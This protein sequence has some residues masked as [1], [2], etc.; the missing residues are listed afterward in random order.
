MSRNSSLAGRPGPSRLGTWEA[1]TLTQPT[2]D[3]ARRPIW[4]PSCRVPVAPEGTNRPVSVRLDRCPT[5]GAEPRP[6]HVRLPAARAGR[7]SSRLRR[8]GHIDRHLHWLAPARHGYAQHGS[9]PRRLNGVEL[10][11]PPRHEEA[12]NEAQHPRNRRPTQA[13][14]EN[15]QPGPAQ[16]KL[17]NAK[18]AQKQRQQNA[19]HLIAA[20]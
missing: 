14:V 7:Q 16:I 4:A 18:T 3:T 13:D 12:L 6:R 19:H 8:L 10:P 11:H 9:N 20:H 2:Q 15:P 17:V 5:R 1:A